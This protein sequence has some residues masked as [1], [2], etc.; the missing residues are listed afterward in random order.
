LARNLSIV[1]VNF[2]TA[3]LVIDLLRSFVAALPTNVRY[4]MII[5]DNNSGDGSIEKLNSVVAF[6]AWHAW[7]T[8]VS[9]GRNGGF[10]FGNNVG[11]QEALRSDQAV[12]YLMLLNPDTIVF[13]GSI[14]A[15]VEFMDAHPSA[16]IAGSLLENSDGALEPSAHRAPSP[17]G[18]LESA[19][20]LGFLTRF[21]QKYAVTPPVRYSPHEC[22]WV[23]GASLVIR[24]E[25]LDAVGVMDEGFFL[26]FEEVDYCMRAR[27]AGWQIWLVPASRILHLEGASTGIRNSRQ[28]RAS[29]WF[30]SR[31]RYFVKHIGVVG[32]VLADILWAV[33]RVSLVL[34]RYLHL[35]SGGSKDDP[36]WFAFDLLWGDF[37]A[38]V[39][40]RA[41]NRSG[42]H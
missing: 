38:L 21:L 37:H 41:F 1:V 14:D 25:V 6:E 4:R 31:R 24:R 2:R 23:S 39:T 22:D 3:D 34:R 18:E 10:A 19:A 8:I 20:R 29:Y 7:V 5:V 15:L 35:G 36:K 28:R 26:Y 11:I 30:D 32:W 16:G 33:G 17:L 27:R 9:A 42:K 12:D 13:P 40:G